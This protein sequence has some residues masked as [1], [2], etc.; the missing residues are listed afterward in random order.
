MI[1]EESGTKLHFQSLY[2][3]ILTR[4]ITSK[5]RGETR[6]ERRATVSPT[7]ATNKLAGHEHPLAYVSTSLSVSL[8]HRILYGIQA[9]LCRSRLFLQQPACPSKTRVSSQ[10]KST[11]ALRIFFLGTSAAAPKECGKGR[12]PALD[13]QPLTGRV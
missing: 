6:E 2:S 1:K 9:P 8:C 11:F 10:G 5:L 13:C 3:P 4:H 12:P 7:S